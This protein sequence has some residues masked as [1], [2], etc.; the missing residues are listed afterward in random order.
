VSVVV[1][2]GTTIEDIVDH[3][4]DTH[5]SLKHE[6]ETETFWL[7]R[8]HDYRLEAGLDSSEALDFPLPKDKK[9]LKL[10]Y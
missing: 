6:H 4:R 9:V 5:P 1:D 10:M 8:L 2:E 7:F 3:I